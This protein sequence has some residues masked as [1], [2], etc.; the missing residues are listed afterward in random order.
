MMINKRL[1]NTVKSSKKYIAGNVV[2]QWCSLIA[3]ILTMY[4][5]ANYIQSIYFRK[6]TIRLTLISAAVLLA[7]L[8]VRFFCTRG[9]SRMSYLSSK[10][11][12]KMLRERIYK[13]LFY[14]NNR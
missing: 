6:I 2:L 1:I 4:I 10:T 3:N 11:V 5:I 14:R 9:V 7:A 8:I 12:K 13:K